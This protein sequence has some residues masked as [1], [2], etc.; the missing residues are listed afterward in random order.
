[1]LQSLSEYLPREPLTQLQEGR[2]IHSQF[3]NAEFDMTLALLELL[4]SH[5]KHN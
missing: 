5:L 3:Y 1:M 2:L 4:R